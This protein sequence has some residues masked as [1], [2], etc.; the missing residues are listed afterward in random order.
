MNKSVQDRP[1]LRN[2][3]NTFTI[4]EIH[5]YVI[6]LD[7]LPIASWPKLSDSS[8]INSLPADTQRRLTIP[9]TSLLLLHFSQLI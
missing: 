3:G 4:A 9:L 6:R 8:A 2:R 1:A 7:A 5:P